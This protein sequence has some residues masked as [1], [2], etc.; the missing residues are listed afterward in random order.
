MGCLK[1]LA[2]LGYGFWGLVFIIYMVSPSNDVIG[3]Y[4]LLFLIVFI[5]LPIGYLLDLTRFSKLKSFFNSL[6]KIILNIFLLSYIGYIIVNLDSNSISYNSLHISFFALLFSVYLYFIYIK[7]YLEKSKSN[8]PAKPGQ[9]APSD[10]VLPAGET[11]FT[12]GP[13]IGELGQ[14]GIKTESIFFFS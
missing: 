2:I 5:L 1:K 4:D 3:Y 13:M 14:L 6:M 9:T 11:P 12:P 7:P 8:A 10:L